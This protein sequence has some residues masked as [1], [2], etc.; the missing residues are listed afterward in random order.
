MSRSEP[1]SSPP[2]LGA[3]AWPE[4]QAPELQPPQAKKEARLPPA[5]F[6]RPSELELEEDEVD[7]VDEVRS[8][9]SMEEAS[10]SLSVRPRLL[11]CST[12]ASAFDD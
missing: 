4:P 11:R 2:L 3:E 8:E 7:D 5:F 9:D 1:L 10:S 6:V 12:N